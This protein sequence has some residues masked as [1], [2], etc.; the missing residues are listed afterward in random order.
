M[1]T[2]DSKVIVDHVSDQFSSKN[3]VLFQ[4]FL[5]LQTG[6]L[7][8]VGVLDD[9]IQ[10]RSNSRLA[11]SSRSLDSGCHSPNLPCSLTCLVGM[12]DAVTLFPPPPPRSALRAPHRSRSRLLV[13]VWESCNN[14]FRNEYRMTEEIV[15][16]VEW[17]KW[18]SRQAPL[19]NH[20]SPVI[21][22]TI[23]ALKKAVRYW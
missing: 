20:E 22:A 9:L 12:I 10:S 4:D 14:V 15:H 2:S 11:L 1:R 3:R 7:C 16:V 18:A 19:V 8:G 6:L 5:F 17:R 21:G 13:W 23:D